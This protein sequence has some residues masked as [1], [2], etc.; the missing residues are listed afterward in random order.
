M[1]GLFRTKGA[2]VE[3]HTLENLVS[4]RSKANWLPQGID[5]TYNRAHVRTLG[6]MISVHNY[7]RYIFD[8]EHLC[9]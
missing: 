3:P 8:I 9:H 2:Q 1:A 6:P 4:H 5:F 7:H